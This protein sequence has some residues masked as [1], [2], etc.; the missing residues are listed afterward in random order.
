MSDL[1]DA[2]DYQNWTIT[3]LKKQRDE[4]RDLCVLLTDAVD[5]W[6]NYNDTPRFNLVAKAREVLA[7]T[8]PED[9]P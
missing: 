2:M 6:W 9:K 7:R 8:D 1:K 3:Q 5:H 4:L